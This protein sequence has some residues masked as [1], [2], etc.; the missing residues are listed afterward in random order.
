MARTFAS[1][2][3]RGSRLRNEY[4]EPFAPCKHTR[5]STFLVPLAGG[6]ARSFPRASREGGGRLSL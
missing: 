1:A 2:A 3:T 4:V 5:A 6:V